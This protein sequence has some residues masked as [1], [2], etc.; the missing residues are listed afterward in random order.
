MALAR[1]LAADIAIK[2]IP[3]FF[4]LLMAWKRAGR[5]PMRAGLRA[6]P[7]HCFV[8]KSV[9]FCPEYN[10]SIFFGAF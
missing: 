3:H 10:N 6:N 8:K 1:P 5:V 4:L 9:S 7:P 2:F